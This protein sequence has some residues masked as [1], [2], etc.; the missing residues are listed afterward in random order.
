MK[1]LIKELEEKYKG[2][3]YSNLIKGGNNEYDWWFT[4]SP[5]SFINKTLYLMLIHK[6]YKKVF[7]LKINTASQLEN[8]IPRK[9]GVHLSGHY[10]LYFKLEGNDS[11]NVKYLINSN[12]G[13]HKIEKI[14]DY[15]VETIELSE[16]EFIE[17]IEELKDNLLT[18]ESYLDDE[19]SDQ[20]KKFAKSLIQK[21]KNL[22]AYKVQNE[23]HFAPSR[24]V[25]YK[26]NNMYK[27][28][29]NDSKDGRD[30]TPVINKLSN[31]KLSFNP[32]LEDAY[33][34]YCYSL[35]IELHKNKR[36]YFDFISTSF[37][38]LAIYKEGKILYSKHRR[39]ER[40]RKL[41][42]NAKQKFRAENG[43]KIFC[44]ICNF[45][46]REIYGID[47]I[48]VHHMKAMANME[49]DEV[50]SLADVCLVCPNCHRIIHSE[51]PHFTIDK[52]KAL[53]EKQK[54][55]R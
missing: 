17:N 45:N 1:E 38:E 27:H 55:T 7:I 2:L 26:T 31:N 15:I 34:D 5:E 35:N 50:T 37:K 16:Y 46:F 43:N 53:I 54:H 40:N 4:I 22:V 20:E 18:I 30:T 44:E 10:D 8:I 42:E 48:E 29:E 52:V 13:K 32:E 12:N 28:W 25:G 33:I 23:Y 47:Y 14:K 21:G 11:L 49:E 51:T 19:Y 3:R 41:V 39:R 9:E 6:V 36:Q 24:F